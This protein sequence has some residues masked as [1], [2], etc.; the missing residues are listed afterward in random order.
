[1]Q[2]FLAMMLH[3]MPPNAAAIAS[4]DVVLVSSHKF[5]ICPSGALRKGRM[6]ILAGSNLK[7][8]SNSYERKY[9]SA[10]TEL[11]TT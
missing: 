7:H 2:R 5:H 3:P 9:S 8:A 11:L 6:D 10:A 4:I 1:M